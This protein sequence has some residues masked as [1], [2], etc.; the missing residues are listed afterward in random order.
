[1]T[2]DVLG[3]DR[4][5]LVD[6]LRDLAG[7]DDFVG[8]LLRSAQLAAEAG[9]STQSVELV[10][11][12][13]DLVDDGPFAGVLAIEVLG[14]IDHRAAVESLTALLSAPHTLL[15]R[16]PSRA[17]SSAVGVSDAQSAATL[18]GESAVSPPNK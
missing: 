7:S 9:R 18:V 4:L 2:T 10:D 17:R 15:R 16:H 3:R 8:T 12:L 6:E 13:N 14:A 11:E 5:A 1:M